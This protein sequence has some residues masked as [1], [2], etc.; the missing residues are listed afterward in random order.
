M[1]EYPGPQL[2]F[3]STFKGI[4]MVFRFSFILSRLMLPFSFAAFIGFVAFTAFAAPADSAPVVRDSLSKPPRRTSA[5]DSLLKINDSLSSRP[6]SAKSSTMLYDYVAHPVLQAATWPLEY[7]FAPGI[8]LLIFPTRAPL[9][10]FLN[11]NVIDRTIDL[12]TIGPSEKKIM[13]YPTLNL[14]PGTSSYTG[15]TMLNRNLFGRPT[16]QMVARASIYVNGDWKFRDYV[17]ADS[18]LGSGFSSKVSFQVLRTKNTNINQP[19]TNAYW[20]FADS[21]NIYSAGVSHSLL[22]KL[23][24]QFTFY[25][26]DNNYF[27]A[28]PQKDTLQ[29]EFFRDANG[30]LDINST[31]RGLNSSWI[32]RV[33]SF[34]FTRDTRNNEN[35]PLFGSLFN[36]DYSYHFTNASHDYHA[37]QFNWTGFY[38][39]GKEKYE[40]SS[41]EERKAGK[42]SI[43]KVLEKMELE[44]LRRSLLNRKVL[45]LHFTGAQ[46][47][48]ISGNSMPVYGL[49]ALSNDSPLRGYSGP[50][51]RDYSIASASAEYRFPVMRLVDGVMFN[52]YG[53]YGRQWN[54]IDFLDN[55][56]NSWG[57]GIRVRR[58]DIY[59]FRAQL[60]F[61]GLHGIEVNMST[62]E[63]F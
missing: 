36:G 42:L 48:E 59:L 32:D 51:F 15:L 43:G 27:K 62:N 19:G 18:I 7:I 58:P 45:V 41:D 10:Y 11:E 33:F 53:I 57:F 24:G 5:S 40:I 8:E 30:K 35:I 3:D 46:S 31:H 38:K 52:E 49:P 21:S 56:K 34:S 2:G 23:T 26:R 29:S 37:W 17:T 50:R 55:V 20:N 54:K 60:A 47:Y 13:L 6:D 22:E 4:A 25:F 14:A 28:P 61:H 44:N 9:R 63:P 1:I 16:E 39:L 12:I